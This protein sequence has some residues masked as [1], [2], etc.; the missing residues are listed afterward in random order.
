MRALPTGVEVA[1]AL[2]TVRERVGDDTERGA[3]LGAT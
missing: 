3:T 2:R 1:L